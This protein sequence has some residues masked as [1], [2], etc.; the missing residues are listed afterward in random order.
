MTITRG[1]RALSTGYYHD[2][3][4]VPDTDENLSTCVV[5]ESKEDDCHGAVANSWPDSI[6]LNASITRVA[7]ASDATVERV[8]NSKFLDRISLYGA[9][10]I[11]LQSQVQNP[12][13]CCS[14]IVV[15][16][17]NTG[18]YSLENEIDTFIGKDF[19]DYQMNFSSDHLFEKEFL[20]CS[21]SI[22]EIADQSG[23]LK[24]ENTFA[25]C[26]IYPYGGMFEYGMHPQLMESCVFRVVHDGKQLCLRISPLSAMRNLGIDPTKD[27]PSES[28]YQ[29]VGVKNFSESQKTNLYDELKNGFCKIEV[30]NK[31]TE[32]TALYKSN[33]VLHQQ[34]TN[35]ITINFIK[36]ES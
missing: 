11:D 8:E 27:Q 3:A 25:K 10:R 24:H 32:E 29:F 22:S 13:S 30:I 35:L 12:K 36:E 17:E 15:D 33:A 5:F 19:G 20:I 2:F 6:A 9:P 18:K 16:F 31:N 14:K 34:K 21:Q 7:A 4:D 28:G 23:T 26:K 1:I